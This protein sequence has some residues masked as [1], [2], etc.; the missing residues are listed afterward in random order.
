MSEDTWLK[1]LLAKRTPDAIVILAD[2]IQAGLRNGTAS[3]ND[4]QPRALAQ[5]NVVGG[6]FKVLPKFGF[7]HTD[8][9]VK[10]IVPKK[11]ARRVDVWALSNRSKAE[12]FI[13]Y[14][15]RLFMESA[16]PQ[17]ELPL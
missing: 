5:P 16:K 13:R 1:P 3:A 14:Q 4:I 9:R 11:H 7:I 10:T 8:M 6:V 12:A 17:M 2:L 15:Q